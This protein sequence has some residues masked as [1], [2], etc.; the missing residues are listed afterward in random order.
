MR[1]VKA[2]CSEF[3]NGQLSEVCRCVPCCAKLCSKISGRFRN[4]QTSP[5]FMYLLYVSELVP[6]GARAQHPASIGQ[7][8]F[9]ILAFFFK[10]EAEF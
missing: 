3:E 1:D 6:A 10:G 9:L 8:T 5:S 7:P 2:P 4:F